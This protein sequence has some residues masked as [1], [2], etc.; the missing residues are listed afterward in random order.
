MRTE[1]VL[2]PWDAARVLETSARL[3]RVLSL[4][5]TRP[6]WPGPELA[7][8]LGVTT[9][10]LRRDVDKLRSLGY[11]VESAPGR[12]GGYRLGSGAELPPLQFDDDEA[13]AVWAA[14]AATTG[15]AVEG[16]EEAALA[17]LGKIDRLLPP[18]L[19][20]R[21]DA[22]SAATVRLG[23]AAVEPVAADLLVA[24]AGACTSSERLRLG[25]V[26][27][28]GQASERRFDPW[29]LVSTGRRWYLV[30]LD[31]DRDDWRT[32]RVDRVRSATR[33]GH[34]FELVDPPDAAELV[35][36]ATTVAPYRWTAT[37]LVDAEVD[38]VRRRVPPTVAVVEEDGGGR[39]RL[40]TGADSLVAIAGHLVFLDLPFEVVDPPELRTH[41]ATLGRSLAA[42]HE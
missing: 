12:D 40:V 37:V 38:A 23:R 8:R 9:R 25:Y 17:A 18:R 19:R 32:L 2:V 5:Q 22:L 33:T 15:G 21:V 29:R 7:A 35:T 16:F 24:L 20:A 36:R 39:T 3:L 34:R 11:P 14:L 30:G 27:R 6:S 28:D 1:T 26:D 41:L 4:L 10:S 31:V 13:V 42:S